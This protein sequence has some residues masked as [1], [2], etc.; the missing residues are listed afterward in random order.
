ME[1]LMWLHGA[2]CGFVLCTMVIDALESDD[3]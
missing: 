2:A 1:W 3:D